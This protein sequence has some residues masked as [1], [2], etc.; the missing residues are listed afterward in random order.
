MG[1]KEVEAVFKAVM[2]KRVLHKYEPIPGTEITPD[3]LC[4]NGLVTFE[5][6]FL[7]KVYLRVPCI[8]ILISARGCEDRRYAEELQSMDYREF[9]F[10][11]A[12]EFSF[13][14]RD[15]ENPKAQG[16]EL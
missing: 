4:A 8:W 16:C 10:K 14:K 13:D 6:D 12:S 7:G 2:A 1:S 9:R 5:S 11:T 3:E 15:D